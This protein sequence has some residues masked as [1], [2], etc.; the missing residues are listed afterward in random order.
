MLY[1]E[2]DQTVDPAQ[3]RA[4]F[5]RIPGSSKKAIVVDYSESKGQH[6]LAGD[7]LAPK[8]TAPMAASIIDWVRSLP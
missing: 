6:V 7:I 8:A 4:V 3:T 1:S 5:E 2:Q